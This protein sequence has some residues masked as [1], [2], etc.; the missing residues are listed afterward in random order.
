MG[1]PAHPGLGPQTTRQQPSGQ[2]ACQTAEVLTVTFHPLVDESV[3]QGPTV[4]AEGGTGVGVDLKLV[5]A[6]GVLEQR[7]RQKGQPQ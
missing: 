6:P 1:T 5:F 4:V 7:N 3:Q 2:A